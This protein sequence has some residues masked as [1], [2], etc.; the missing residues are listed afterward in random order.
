MS[1]EITLFYKCFCQFLRK[2][3][4]TMFS[5]FEIIKR[6]SQQKGY[7]LQK[8]AEDLSFSVNYL[9]TLKEKTP[10]SDRLQEIADYFNVSTD[11]LLGRTN[12]P[13]IAE[14]I[15]GE[16]NTETLRNIERKAKSLT[17]SDQKKLLKLMSIT[18]ETLLDEDIDD[19]HDF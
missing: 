15:D 18:F 17:P 1:T 12:N 19:E 13:E 14:S 11:Y 3:D 6:L 7:S 5:T 10:K 4:K 9:Y 8:V 16:E 2:V